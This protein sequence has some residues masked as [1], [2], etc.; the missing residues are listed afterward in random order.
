[1]N[2]TTARVLH[3]IP[4]NAQLHGGPSRA[5][6]L[7]EKEL[8]GQGLQVVTATTDDDGHGRHNNKPLGRPLQE[9]G[10]TRLYFRKQTDF[11]KTSLGLGWWT[12][13]HARDFD[14]VHIHAL[15]SF[16]T[17]VAAWSARLAGV[18]YVIR[19]LGTLNHY[20]VTQRRPWL[21]KL[22]LALL[23]GPALRHAAAVHFTSEDEQREAAQWGMPMR[24]VVISLGIEAAGAVEATLA[25]DIFPG[26]GKGSYILFVGRL[27]PVKNLEGLLRA[28]REVAARWAALRLLIAGDGARDYVAQLK[29][30]AQELDLADK[31]VWA[32]HVEG[33]AKA[34]LLAGAAAFVLPSFSENFGIAA[35]EA[36]MAGLPCVLGQGVAISRDVVDAGAGV[37]VAPDPASIAAGLMQVMADA[38]V[39][40]TMSSRA[41]ALAQE[42]YSAQ[43]MG[44]N[45]VALYEDILG[46][47][48]PLASKMAGI[49]K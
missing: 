49:V 26:L 6:M 28:F 33:E 27:N 17:L 13:R 39:R 12:L 19:P 8:V 37:A 24:G 5:L 44:V 30:L 25:Q 14:V 43:A 21:K 2:D 31:V 3:V 15:F 38:Q 7:M 10:V 47:R 42:K 41:L 1:M 11:Y 20:G 45:L 29:A 34:S 36:L 23:E 4:S 48:Q 9:N 32:G 35:A 46:R 40:A 18:P 22:S 16:T